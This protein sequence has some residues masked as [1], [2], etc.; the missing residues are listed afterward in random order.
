MT[1]PAKY[2]LCSAG[3]AGLAEP[4]ALLLELTV[5]A[6]IRATLLDE[7]PFTSIPL[8]NPSCTGRGLEAALLGAQSFDV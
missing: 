2:W 4:G 7:E 6:T 5:S 8:I 3:G 1:S